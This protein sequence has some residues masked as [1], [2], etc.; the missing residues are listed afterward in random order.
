MRVAVRTDIPNSISE[1]NIAENNDIPEIKITESAPS[2][3]PKDA[4][5]DSKPS[6]SA[7]RLNT[8][9]SG[10]GKT[11]KQPASKAAVGSKTSGKA[12]KSKSSAASSKATVVKEHKAASNN[13]QLDK[14]K[15]NGSK[16]TVKGGSKVKKSGSNSK[17]SSSSSNSKLSSSSNFS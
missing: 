2:N 15:A 16:L 8:S 13:N 4:A 5:A 6:S 14:Q 7:E 9:R 12:P 1:A 3:V 11:A 17:L 10:D